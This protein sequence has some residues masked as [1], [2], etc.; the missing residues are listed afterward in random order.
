MIKITREMRKTE[1]VKTENT[2]T[3]VSL[4]SEGCLTLRKYD[5]NN[6][7]R[8]E[9]IIF[10]QAETQEIVKL[11]KKFNFLCGNRTDELPF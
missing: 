2:S 3:Q 1:T 8:D 5:N 7:D 9:I 6:K 11:F 10:T 4:N